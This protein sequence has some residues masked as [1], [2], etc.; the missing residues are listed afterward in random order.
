MSDRSWVRVDF[1]VVAT[2]KRFVAE[3]VDSLV[4][5]TRDVLLGL[6][7]LQAVGLVPA[8]RENV[9]RDLAPNRVTMRESEVRKGEE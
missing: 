6:D 4:L 5:D 8:G 2:S 3:K 9:K 1:V 7:V